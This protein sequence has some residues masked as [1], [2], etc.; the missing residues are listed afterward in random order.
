MITGGDNKKHCEEVGAYADDPSC[1]S[2]RSKLEFVPNANS[3]F[4]DLR[5]T[6]EGTKQVEENEILP[7][8]ETKRFVFAETGYRSSR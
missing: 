4:Y 5:A 2:Y 3:T 1:W 8:R 6:S 7:I